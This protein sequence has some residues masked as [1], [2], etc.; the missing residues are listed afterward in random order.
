[1]ARK[2]APRG[3]RG[4]VFTRVMRKTQ[5]RLKAETARR[6]ELAGR[7]LSQA[8]VVRDMI[9]EALAGP[10]T[11]LILRSKMTVKLAR[12]AALSAKARGYTETAKRL[13][14]AARDI[15]DLT[16]HITRAHRV[17]V[18]S[19]PC[20]PTLVPASPSGRPAS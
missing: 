15:V 10:P 20:P 13:E 6:S 9:A 8:D 2:K 18:E 17:G 1:M 14:E 3:L 4:V 19:P 5:E 7:P 16:T 11:Q 12:E